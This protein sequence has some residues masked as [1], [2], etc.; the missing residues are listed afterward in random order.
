[1]RNDSR[2][3]E[4]RPAPA[5]EGHVPASR[6]RRPAGSASRL[7]ALSVGPAYRLVLLGAYIMIVYAVVLGAGRV[8]LP[9]PGHAR[10]WLLAISATVVATT[11]AR[12]SR[13]YGDGALPWWLGRTPADPYRTLR[14]LTRKLSADPPLEDVLPRLAALLAE[15]TSARSASVWLAIDERTVRAARWPEAAVPD[16]PSTVASLADLSA[17]PD[18]DHAVA[19]HDAGAP[20]GALTVRCAPGDQVTPIQIRLM[21]DLANSAGLL[22]SNVRLTA[23]L[24]D[25]VRATAAAVEAV[26]SSRQR[27][28]GAQDVARQRLG[29][30]IEAHLVARLTAV[31]SAVDDLRSA[32]PDGRLSDRGALRDLERQ[33]D[34]VIAALR[35]LVRRVYPSVLIDHGLPAAIDG[36]CAGMPTRVRLRCHGVR[37]YPPTVESAVYFCSATLLHRWAAPH[38]HPLDLSVADDGRYLTVTLAADADVKAA[39]ADATLEDVADRMAALGGELHLPGATGSADV[40]ARLVMPVPVP[41]PVPVPVAAPSGAVG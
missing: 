1:M 41:G 6:A 14:A 30:E 23:L 35:R 16:T 19:V 11:V 24:R 8:L 7:F 13:R 9:R 38:G 27:L 29:H 25:R 17:L 31:C 10:G 37:R 39:D 36:L 26:R 21:S 18:V 32:V 5:Q 34:E 3:P 4:T 28:L 12:I 33:A 20:V 15:G 22:L 2:K 40:L